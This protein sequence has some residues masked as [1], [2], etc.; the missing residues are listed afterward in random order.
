MRT[1]LPL[2]FD[3]AMLTV[4]PSPFLEARETSALAAAANV[5]HRSRQNTQVLAL[6]TAAGAA[7]MSDA[8]IQQ[9]TGLSRQTICLR[10]HDLRAFLTP[11]D[12]RAVS[13]FGRAMTTWRRRRPEEMEA[14]S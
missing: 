1:Q 6:I 8:E 7:G 2:D 14:G 11:G 10:R 9:A 4:A 3:A 5:P 13:P 12:R